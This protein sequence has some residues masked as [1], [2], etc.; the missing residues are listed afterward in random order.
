M[1]LHG[2]M[3]NTLQTMMNSRT[4]SRLS[5]RSYLETNDWGRLRWIANSFCVSPATL[6][7]EI[8]RLKRASYSSV[9]TVFKSILTNAKQGLQG[10]HKTCWNISQKR[11]FATANVRL[12]SRRQRALLDRRVICDLLG[13]HEDVYRGV[14]RLAAKWCA[15]PSVH[16]GKARPKSAVY[17]E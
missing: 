4:S 14:R 8:S 6:R 16:G 10:N 15:E 17:V 2:S 1:M 5:L 11:L 3:F 9:R 7:A 12:P 13:F